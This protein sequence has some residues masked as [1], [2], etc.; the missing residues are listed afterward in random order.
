[1]QKVTA[2]G[3]RQH[4]R[5]EVVEGGQT[6]DAGPK[7]WATEGADTNCGRPPASCNVSSENQAEYTELGAH[8]AVG[9]GQ[10]SPLNFFSIYCPPEMK[11]MKMTAAKRDG[12]SIVGDALKN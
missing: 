10:D 3:Q 7:G 11:E 9:K 12:F 6:A 4:D 8:C 2:I 1:M 5:A